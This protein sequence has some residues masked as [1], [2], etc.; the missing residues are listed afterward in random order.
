MGEHA[1][2]D[3]LFLEAIRLSAKERAEFVG[4][5]PADLR[6]RLVILLEAHEAAPDFLENPAVEPPPPMDTTEDEPLTEEPGTTIDRYKLLQ[7]LGEGGFGAVYMAEQ[8]EPVKR[9]VAL[10]II[11]LGMDT[12][13]VIARFEAERQ[14]LAMMDH[15]NI[16]RVLDAGATETGRPYFVMELVK[17]VPIT[18]YCDTENLTTRE[19]L[20]L[21]L[22]V[23]NA[24]QHAHQKRIIH[25]D[26]KP[27]NVMVTLHD[28]VPVP[29]V[30]DFGI[31]KATN[32][33]L[34]DKTL[35][36]EYRQ[37]I[38]TPEYMSPEQAEM[39]GLDIDT[40]SDIYA[41]G[42]LLYE[43]LTG[44]TPFDG[45][46]LRSAALNE[47]QRII[48]EEEPQKP[49]TRFSFLSVEAR[50]A[51]SDD[52]DDSSQPSTSAA[53]IAKHR[54]TD[55]TSLTRQLRGDLDWIVMKALEKDRARR[56]ETANGFAMDVERYLHDEPVL[57]S[58]PT[59]SYKLVK[60][61]RRNK[62]VFT[63]VAA[64]LVVLLLGV[65][66]TSWGMIW[67]FEQRERV[68]AQASRAGD[69]LRQ[70]TDEFAGR[71]LT[72]ATTTTPVPV[73]NPVTGGEVDA[74]AMTAVNLVRSLDEANAA[75]QRELARAS[76]VKR[77]IKEMLDGISPEEAQGADTTLLKGILDRAAHRLATG[78]IEDPL[79]AAEL[80]HTVGSVYEKLSHYADA[81]NHIPT[82]VKIRTRI[83]GPEHPD[84]LRSMSTLAGLFW[85]QGR[86]AEAE[87]LQVETLDIQRRTLGPEHPAT[88]SSA[89]NLANTYAD[90]GRDEE[91]E[92]LYVETL[93]IR[94]RTLG[95]EHPDTLKTM[96]NLAVLYR[97]QGRY[98]DAEPLYAKTLEIQERTLGA[99]HPDTLFSMS[100][101]ADLYW[102]QGRYADGEALQAETLQIRKRVLGPEHS[103][104]LVSMNS[105]AIL[106]ATQGR[107]AEAEP[108]FVQTLE[109]Q[110]RTLGPEHRD[111]LQS[112][113]N[114]ALLCSVQGRYAE[115]EPLLVEALQIQKRTLGPEHPESLRSMHSLAFLYRG[116]GRFA[117]AEPLYLQTLEIQKRALGPEHPETVRTMNNL[118]VLYQDQ[119][120][121]AEAERL[122]LDVLDI[123][124]R[125]HGPEHPD[126]LGTMTNLG[127]LYNSIEQHADAARLLETCLP[128]MRRVLGVQHPSTL[129][130]IDGLAA[131]CE[132]LGRRD[133][134]LEL[135][136]EIEQS[137]T[138]QAVGNGSQ[139]DK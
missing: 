61:F 49:S 23:C 118:S 11:K 17:G 67:A 32:R 29:K 10:K 115:A 16:A 96:N 86:Y 42:V 47:V 116:Q 62:G 28:G 13:Q 52:A 37:F 5:C 15:P 84:T 129:E 7:L 135:R 119:D 2:I 74:L 101:L 30:I 131:A 55:P 75:A 107:Y 87:S 88:R 56:Y 64:V 51:G 83:L 108:L 112:M 94:V 138:G 35:F 27:S 1:P 93:E 76:E 41:L 40:R 98:V 95:P 77:L 70:V 136:R 80:H 22:K 113:N 90:Q 81:E 26:L 100:N 106:Y 21:F 99:E 139:D 127:L 71:V 89:H 3:D 33:E 20:D 34:T 66:G 132:A 9:K 57:A 73:V 123:L 12:K 24:V 82:A 4:A 85:S 91:A 14:A 114:L 19:R 78:E 128:I 79:I 117:E 6:E 137:F 58:P 105:L 63:A 133:E 69:A 126:T 43:L 110:K 97:D 45:T 60:L 124:K 36:T 104:T 53:S 39:S 120:R 111:T 65:I 134:A 8:K 59:A 54:R 38:G 92:P 102:R 50:R 46:R 125:T 25:R 18:E 68:S 122:T 109:I 72:N 130:A 103:D 121:Y 48:R 31:A 44:V